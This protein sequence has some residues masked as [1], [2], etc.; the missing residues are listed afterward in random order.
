MDRRAFLTC[1]VVPV[2]SGCLGNV[3]GDADG[4]ENTTEE[5]TAERQQFI[6]CEEHYIRTELVDDDERIDGSLDPAVV[7]LDTREAGI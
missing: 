7:E 4:A 6:N 2:A 1:A 5:T 3:P